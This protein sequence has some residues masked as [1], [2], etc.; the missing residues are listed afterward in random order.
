MDYRTQTFIARL[1]DGSTKQHE[2]MVY[3]RHSNLKII[4]TPNGSLEAVRREVLGCLK[5]DDDDGLFKDIF[6]PTPPYTSRLHHIYEDIYKVIGDEN[7]ERVAA[8]DSFWDDFFGQ[9]KRALWDYL[10]GEYQFNMDAEIKML[11]R[12]K[13]KLQDFLQEGMSDLYEYPRL[14]K[15]KGEDDAWWTFIIK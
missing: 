5:D 4:I 10:D 6:L 7:N 15:H 11:K 8:V 12:K 3:F 13:R 14:K 2:F 9:V 1:L